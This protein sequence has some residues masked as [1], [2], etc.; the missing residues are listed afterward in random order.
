MELPM[1]G[2]PT[3]AAGLWLESPW[4]LN[5]ALHVPA[6][7][8]ELLEHDLATKARPND[9]T[10]TASGTRESAPEKRVGDLL[11]GHGLH[12]PQYPVLGAAIAVPNIGT[13]GSG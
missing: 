4:R 12:E 9:A 2:P 13:T 11:R 7:V 1:L 6:S 3:A 8:F 5:T 10:E